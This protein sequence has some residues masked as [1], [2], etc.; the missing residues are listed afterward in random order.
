MEDEIDTSEIKNEQNKDKSILELLEEF[1]IKYGTNLNLETSDI[2]LS[3]K[4]IGDEGFQL[5]SQIPFKQIN[6]INLSENKISDISPLTKMNLNNLIE[7]NL[8]KNRIIS[9]EIFEKLNLINLQR[10]YFSY[11]KIRDIKPLTKANLTN[12]VQLDLGSNLISDINDLEFM[13]CVHLETIGLEMNEIN[14][15]SVFER[16]N[17]PQLH[18][19]VFANNYFDH[20]LVKNHDIISNLRKKG[21]DVKIYGSV[22]QNLYQYL[23]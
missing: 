12:L 14:D 16:V 21:C 6:S 9:I 20:E 11:N 2:D 8:S 5:L 3:S 23:H 7:L 15:I 13:Y 18:E 17:F 19:L 4:G 1:N 10:L 22:R